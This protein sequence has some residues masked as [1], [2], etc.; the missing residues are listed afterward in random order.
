MM[1]SGPLLVSMAE[2]IR[3]LRS[4]MLIRSTVISTPASFPN[5]VASR[6]N[7]TSE[8][9][10]KLTHSRMLSLV[11]FG[12]LGAFCA[13]TIAGIPPPAAAPTA[14]PAT[15][16][17]ARR[18]TR[19]AY[20]HG[21]TPRNDGDHTTDLS[22]M[23]RVGP[24]VGQERGDLVKPGLDV[25]LA[26]PDQGLEV[27]RHEHHEAQQRG[28]RC[29]VSAQAADEEPQPP[30]ETVFT[31]RGQPGQ[32]LRRP[33]HEEIDRSQLTPF[34]PAELPEQPIQ[35]LEHQRIIVDEVEKD[36]VQKDPGHLGGRP[37]AVH[38]RL[39]SLRVG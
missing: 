25:R 33:E 18:F 30:R 6:L 38:G 21:P 17:N 35:A 20:L 13:A 36:R 28:P 31:S 26:D 22:S 4:F 2:A 11:P 9:G 5:S 12:K 15:L 1:M 7:S 32:V 39:V 24:S 8:A 27:L 14:T 16:R 10:T 37:R 29:L 34:L 23:S 3:G 19:M